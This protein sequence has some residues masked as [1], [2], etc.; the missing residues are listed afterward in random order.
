MCHGKR[1]LNLQ[2]CFNW[3]RDVTDNSPE[4]FLDSDGKLVFAAM[5]N[6]PG[7]PDGSC[8]VMLRFDQRDL[9]PG[10][11]DSPRQSNREGQ[12]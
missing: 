11:E 8:D 2:V 12:R 7:G 5:R 9:L 3:G 10:D 4:Y 6:V 1:G